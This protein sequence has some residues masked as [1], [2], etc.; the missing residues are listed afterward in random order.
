MIRSRR[1][2]STGAV[3]CLVALVT[4][5]C[6][7]GG[8]DKESGNVSNPTGFSGAVPRGGSL[9]VGAEEELRCADWISNCATPSWGLYTIQEH[10]MPRVFDFQKR[11]NQWTEVPN[12]VLAGEPS[13]TSPTSPAGKQIVTYNINPKAV[14]SDGQPITSTDFK[15]TWDQIVHGR[16]IYDTTGYNQIEGIDDSDPK[17][18]VVTFSRPYA[19]W[20]A[21]FG[22]FYGI[23]PSHILA[24]TDRHT[25]MMNGYDW[26]GGPWLARWDKGS[27]VV[28]TPN[29]RWYGEKPRLDQVT[30]KFAHS[31]ADEFA[32]FR[33]GET[34]AIYPQPQ[35]DAI[36]AVKKGFPDAN[37]FYTA[38][39]GNIEALWMNVSRPGLNSRAVRQAIGYAVDRDA[40]VK[41]LFAPVGVTTAAQTLN[42]PIQYAYSDP[43]AWATY[44]KNLGQVTTLMKG[45]GWTK[46]AD[47]VWAKDGQTATFTI[48]STTGSPRRREIERMLQSQLRAAGF[49]LTVKNEPS[50]QLFT[51]SLPSG[52]YDLA[53]YAQIA[54]SVQPGLC[55]IFCTANIPSPANGFTGQNYGRVS[56]AA[57]QPLTV[58][59]TNL[60]EPAREAAGKQADQILAAEQVALPLD[61]LPNVL[62]WSKRV[63]GPVHDDPVLGMFGN[64]Y[65]WGLQ[66]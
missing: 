30:F 4:A 66:K 6:T 39:T 14:W 12:V 10:T 54:T 13:V 3:V 11:D 37:S 16:D 27:Q 52:D 24:N 44:K 9:V 7:G 63:V 43:T 28:L 23:L 32:S 40:I 18:A 20:K 1:W 42:P 25:A 58:V 62:L 53:L 47:G 29:P 19:G 46:N 50:D 61:P 34:L 22:A 57:D 35:T 59:A 60:E 55:S 36:A 41:K 2:V 33:R 56:T 5:A 64:L 38:D 48:K 65:Q 21:L 17:T 31:A 51:R 45:D 8:D 49:A 15:Y 26:S